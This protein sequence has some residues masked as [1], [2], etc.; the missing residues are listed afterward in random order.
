MGINLLRLKSSKADQGDSHYANEA[1][2][3]NK[4][5]RGIIPSALDYC[6]GTCRW[7]AIETLQMTSIESGI[8][9]LNART[10]IWNF[11]SHYFSQLITLESRYAPWHF[12]QKLREPTQPVKIFISRTILHSCIGDSYKFRAS[13]TDDCQQRSRKKPA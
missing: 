8:Q 12:T 11:E 2:F 3:N 1:L 5:L 4:Y 9:D 13:Q 7:A 10:L 6:G